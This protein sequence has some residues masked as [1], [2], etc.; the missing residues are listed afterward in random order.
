[1]GYV[2]VIT[3][4]LSCN[5]LSIGVKIGCEE[6]VTEIQDRKNPVGFRLKKFMV[7]ANG[8]LHETPEE[9]QMWD[10]EFGCLLALLSK[11]E[12]LFEI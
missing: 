7:D 5:N 2:F 8:V 4:I 11:I 12:F 6:T 3:E 1:M 10:I 9:P